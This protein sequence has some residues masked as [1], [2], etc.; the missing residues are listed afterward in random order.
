MENISAQNMKPNATLQEIANWQLAPP[1]DFQVGLP[2]LQ[3]G[4]VWEPV[5]VINLW[6]SILRGF[7]VGA[8]LLSEVEKETLSST[9]AVQ[10]WL[11]DGQQR[12]TTVAMGFYNPWKGHAH[13]AEIEKKQGWSLKVIPTLWLDLCP[14]FKDDEKVFSPLLVNQSHPWGYDHSGKVLS[15]GDRR[16]ALKVLAAGAGHDRY[17]AF[18]QKDVFPWK[19]NMPV[20]LAFLTEC[21]HIC[22]DGNIEDFKSTLLEQCQSLPDAWKNRFERILLSIP[23]SNITSFQEA[24]LSL[25]KYSIH[26]NYLTHLTKGADSVNSDDNSILF[27][28]LNTGGKVLSGEELI[29]SLYKSV[30]PSAKDAVEMA[31]AGFMPSSRLFSL[32]VRLIVADE[33]VG[34][35]HQSVSLRD[36]KIKIADETFKNRLEAFINGEIK[37]IMEAAKHLL[38]GE[39]CYRLPEALATRTINDA[40]DVFLALLY[41]LKQGGNVEIGSDAHQSLIGY[42]SALSWFSGGNSRQK[43]QNLKQWMEAFKSRP[44]NEFWILDVMKPLFVRKDSPSPSFPSPSILQEFLDESIVQ[45]ANYNWGSLGSTCPKHKIYS[46]YEHLDIP[47]ETQPEDG[48]A[49]KVLRE[50]AAR[51]NL[52]SFIGMLRGSLSLL[53][54]SQRNFI[55]REFKDFQQWDVALEDT[56][57]PWDWDHIYPSSHRKWHV[58]VKYREWHNTIGNKRAEELS[59]NRGNGSS[60]PCDKLQDG[61][62]RSDSFI[63]DDIWLMMCSV[64]DSQNIK[65]AATA[66][67]ICRIILHRMVCIY[68][69]WYKTFEI[70]HLFDFEAVPSAIL[71]ERPAA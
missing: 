62:T 19:A 17:T 2:K 58:S 25:G 56:N 13:I 5:K 51:T 18:R 60:L 9:V 16:D 26:L 8:L 33:D 24:G 15:R 10:Y 57:R 23:T 43:Q 34:K 31:A 47:E 68:N 65:D 7:P 41:W 1:I 70:G 63:P 40:P 53:L 37:P 35:L 48:E 11:L 50:T 66:E 44:M 67:A 14:N 61:A 39:H 69:E 42:F 38:T 4:F 32:L 64:S 22:P 49:T 36:F 55:T 29:F 12:A 3:R 27:V 52:R 21:A 59:H 20:P 46:G 6:D 54:F 28:R 30:F 45:N 71:V